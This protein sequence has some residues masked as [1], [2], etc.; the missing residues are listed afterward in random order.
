MSGIVTAAV[1][2]VFSPTFRTGVSRVTAPDRAPGVA[3]LLPVARQGAHEPEPATSTVLRA[4]FWLAMPE[5]MQRPTQKPKT[6]TLQQVL[7]GAERAH[8]RV[9]KW[10]EWKRQLH[11]DRLKH[12]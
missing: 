11:A 1:D 12:D 4:S 10:P 5:E 7:E 6:L 3:G 8:E 9:L 2:D